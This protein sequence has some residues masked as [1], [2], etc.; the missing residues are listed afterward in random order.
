MQVAGLNSNFTTGLAGRTAQREADTGELQLPFKQAESQD[1]VTLSPQAQVI[2]KIGQDNQERTEQL[3]TDE[4]SGSS[5]N[6]VKVTSSIGQAASR[7]GLN[8]QE[9]IELYKKIDELV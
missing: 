4:S 7:F 8:E 2:Q 3:K 5:N 9:A 1:K 6:F